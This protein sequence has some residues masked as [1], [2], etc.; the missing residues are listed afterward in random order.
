MDEGI[1]GM[2]SQAIAAD[3]PQF[4]TDGVPTLFAATAGDRCRPRSMQWVVGSRS[5]RRR[6]RPSR[7]SA[8]SARRLPAELGVFTMPTL[9]IHGDADARSRSRSRARSRRRFRGAVSSSTPARRTGSSSPSARGSPP[10][11]CASSRE[12][13]M[14]LAARSRS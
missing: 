14:T 2:M 1:G 12:L 13:T 9:V 8:R 10:T 5:R 6:S 11:S 3:R 4:L 7:A